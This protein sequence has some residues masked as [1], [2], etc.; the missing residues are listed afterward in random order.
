MRIKGGRNRRI[1]VS[2]ALMRALWDY[3]MTHRVPHA[4]LGMKVHGRELAE[5][6]VSAHG[7]P[8]SA[9][10]IRS[11]LA[12][13]SQRAGI[14]FKVHPHMLRHTFATHEIHALKD[15]PNTAYALAV[16]RDRLGHS[17]IQTTEK[18]LHL[19]HEIEHAYLSECQLDL[20]QLLAEEGSP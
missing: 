16:V 13:A 18:Y 19:L 7:N 11:A 3:A 15:K 1:V 4:R 8:F 6:F 10:A 17:S 14:G 12:Q 20:D 9:S 5:L 2:R